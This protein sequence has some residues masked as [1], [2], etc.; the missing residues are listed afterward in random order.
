MDAE[1]KKSAEKEGEEK[2]PE[3]RGWSGNDLALHHSTK[4]PTDKWATVTEA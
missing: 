4:S 3:A 1:E 2:Y